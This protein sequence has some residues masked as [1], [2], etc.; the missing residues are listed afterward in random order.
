M[1][2]QRLSSSILIT[3]LACSAIAQTNDLVVYS[4]DGTKFTLL[5]DGDQK[6]AAPD[7][8]VVAT[9]IRTATPRVIHLEQR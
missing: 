9:G 7:T 6:N 2:M 3:L 5:V 8:R 4:D 1:N